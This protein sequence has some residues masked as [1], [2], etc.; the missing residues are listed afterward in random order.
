MS[1]AQIA[2]VPLAR[3]PEAR[4]GAEPHAPALADDAGARQ[5]R[6]RH[7]VARAAGLVDRLGAAP[8]MSCAITMPNRVELIIGLFAACAARRSGDPRKSRADSA[9]GAVPAR[10]RR[11]Q[12]RHRGRPR[13]RRPVVDVDALAAEPAAGRGRPMTRG[14]TGWRCLIYTSG[15]TGKPKGV[16]LDHANISAMGEM[17]QRRF[18]ITD[19]DHSLL[20][21]PLFHVNGIVVRAVSPMLAGGRVRSRGASA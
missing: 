17:T 12:G 21:L 19:V 3:L 11:R 4:A 13:A 18:G 14:P 2:N 15:S 20:V 7:R 8:A 9:G 10:Q 16:M 6:V 1:A 5:R